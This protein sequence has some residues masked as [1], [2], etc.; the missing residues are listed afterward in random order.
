[1]SA[2]L[3][4]I[5]N[6]LTP[7]TSSAKPKNKKKAGTKNLEPPTALSE[8]S[9]ALNSPRHENIDDEAGEPAHVREVKK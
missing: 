5:T 6:T 4:K 7:E 1:M 2:I 8:K 3:Q 9:S